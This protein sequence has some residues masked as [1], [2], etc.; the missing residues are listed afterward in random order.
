MKVGPYHWACDRKNKSR[1]SVPCFLSAPIQTQ[2]IYNPKQ[3]TFALWKI[4]KNTE[5]TFPS[6]IPIVFRG[7]K[8]SQIAKRVFISQKNN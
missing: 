4:A 7:N 6:G 2:A 3:E 5:L 8:F 1:A